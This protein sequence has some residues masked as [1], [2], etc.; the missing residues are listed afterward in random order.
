MGHQHYDLFFSQNTICSELGKFR[1]LTGVWNQPERVICWR[2][3]PHLPTKLLLLS[4]EW[5]RKGAVIEYLLCS[6]RWIK[7]FCIVHLIWGVGSGGEIQ[8]N[9]YFNLLC[10]WWCIPKEVCLIPPLPSDFSP[11]ELFGQTSARQR[12]RPHL[13]AFN[14]QMDWKGAWILSSWR[15]PLVFWVFFFPFF[16]RQKTA[17]AGDGE[18]YLSCWA[19]G[20]GRLHGLGWREWQAFQW[21]RSSAWRKGPERGGH[22]R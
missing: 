9:I 4:W 10:I 1:H 5:K 18:H 19:E 6:R 22:H 14:F 7:H 3:K 2:Q 15:E 20:W 12:R 17:E 13:K 8:F 11:C 21:M 16:Q